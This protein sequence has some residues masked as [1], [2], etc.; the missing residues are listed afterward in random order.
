MLKI[1]LNFKNL[2]IYFQKINYEYIHKYGNS[3]ISNYELTIEIHKA[4]KTALATRESI[5]I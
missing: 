1:F 3:L 2:I 5:K 4:K